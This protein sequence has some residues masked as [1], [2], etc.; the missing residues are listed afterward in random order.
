MKVLLAKHAGFCWGVVRAI[1]M[2]RSLAA[3][4][5]RVYTDGPLIHNKQMTERLEAEGIQELGDYQSSA[6]LSIDDPQDAITLVRAHGISPQRR[7]YLK[8]LGTQFKDA[9]CPDVGIIAGKIRMHAKKGYATL[10]F[11]TPGHPEVIGLMGYTEGLGHVV[12]TPQDVDAL[13]DIN[14]PL[15]FVS[16]STMFTSDFEELAAYI[17]KRFPQTLVFDTI[18]QAT[19]DRQNDLDLF[20]KEQVDAIIVVGGYHSANTKKLA[21][22][23]E[24]KGLPCYHIESAQ[25]LQEAPVAQQ[26]AQFSCVGVT[27]GASTPEFIIEAVCQY[28]ESLRGRENKGILA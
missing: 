17:K 3:S 1:E 15:C 23:A 7:A 27:A 11:G 18:C 20:V 8:S 21:L 22:L 4:G 10:V 9:T 19:K 26:L 5:Q 14:G 2:S 16:Q 24:R 25:Q 28:L 13:P 12:E 6:D